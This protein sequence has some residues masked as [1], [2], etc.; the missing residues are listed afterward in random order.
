MT[1]MW[2]PNLGAESSQG[3][4]DFGFLFQGQ[5]PTA[6]GKCLAFSQWHWGEGGGHLSTQAGSICP[7]LPLQG[8]AE[9]SSGQS[10][11]WELVP[12][13]QFPDVSLLWDMDSD[14]K[15]HCVSLLIV[16]LQILRK[17]LFQWDNKSPLVE[18]I[19]TAGQA[20]ASW[21][22][23]S[24]A[25]AQQHSIKI[26]SFWVAWAAYCSASGTGEVGPSFCSSVL[27]GI[28]LLVG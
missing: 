22:S 27:A 6:P 25:W 13:R 19:P 4:L 15:V 23:A 16:W 18:F 8:Q 2:D 26:K 21:S 10:E 20:G 17:T 24:P 28:C 11:C 5:E 12:S 9:R 3:C 1:W 7:F 14:S